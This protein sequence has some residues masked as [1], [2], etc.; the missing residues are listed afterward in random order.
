M[1]GEYRRKSPRDT[2]G[3]VSP[4]LLPRTYIQHVEYSA[5]THIFAIKYSHSHTRTRVH[6]DY[7]TFFMIL[8]L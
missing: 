2:P 8:L 4:S 6:K 1:K 7:T 5:V 3:K